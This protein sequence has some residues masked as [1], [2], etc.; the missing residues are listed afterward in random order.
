M[1]KNEEPVKLI[2]VMPSEREKY[3]DTTLLQNA[4][5]IM[6]DTY[7]KMYNSIKSIHSIIKDMF[8]DNM[9]TVENLNKFNKYIHYCEYSKKKRIRNKY[10]NKIKKIIKPEYL[11][12]MLKR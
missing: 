2:G 12:E 11:E 10:K 1:S 3:I 7:R 8:Q 6:L 4:T 5:S 9:F